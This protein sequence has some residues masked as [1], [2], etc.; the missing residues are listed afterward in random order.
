M[1]KSCESLV[2]VVV[3]SII[4]LSPS[5]LCRAS[6]VVSIDEYGVVEVSITLSLDRGVHEIVAPIE[7]IASTAIATAD[8]SA[9]P[10]IY[11]NG[12]FYIVL[13]TEANVTI[14]YIAN[15][16]IIN[17]IFYLDIVTDDTVSIKIH[18]DVILLSW[19]G[20]KL[21]DA[22]VEQDKLVLVIRGPETIRYTIRLPSLVTITSPLTRIPTT[23]TETPVQSSVATETIT[24]ELTS[25]VAQLQRPA[26]IVMVV[27]IATVLAVGVATGFYLYRSRL[28]KPSFISDMLN[29]IDIAIIR[30]LEA[31]GDSAL[32]TELQN[33]VNI[34][35]T[36]L[37]RHIRKLEKLGIVKVEKIGLQNR[38][39]LI[40]KVKV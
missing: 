12:S 19:P 24:T 23:T 20:E 30:A 37:W 40:K 4:V 7:P 29:D 11:D 33:D 26:D 18:R 34:P 10:L 15:T 9:L 31:R 8:D 14:T 27:T 39:V 35:R 1:K 5:I 36:T 32:Q 6:N 22:R 16:S 2:L 17:N 25:A 38:I 21:V 3:A 13:N 28:K